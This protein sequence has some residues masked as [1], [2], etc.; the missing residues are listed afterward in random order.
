MKCPVCDGRL[1]WR[2]RAD[3]DERIEAKWRVCDDPTCR[4][5]ERYPDHQRPAVMGRQ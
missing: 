4:Y 5:D 2:A 3:S 1:K